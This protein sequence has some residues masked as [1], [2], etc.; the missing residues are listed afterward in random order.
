MLATNRAFQSF[1]SIGTYHPY[2]RGNN[3]NFDH[4]SQQILNLKKSRG[5]AIRFF[6]NQVINYIENEL[7]YDISIITY[8]PSHEAHK[9]SKSGIAIVAEIVAVQC[10]LLFVDCLQRVRTIDKLSY[11]GCRDITVHMNSIE[12]VKKELIYNKNILVLDDV[13]TTGN[14]L[15]ACAILL[16]NTGVNNVFCLSLAQTTS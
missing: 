13:S 1:E 10:D 15:K 16:N 7:N 4:W 14:S 3:P 2:R 6:K 8:V 12:V 5:E 9:T 11:G